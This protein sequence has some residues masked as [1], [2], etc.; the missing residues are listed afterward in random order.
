MEGID[1]EA[2]ESVIRRVTQP[3]TWESIGWMN[4]S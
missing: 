2:I 3:F 1:S 4:E